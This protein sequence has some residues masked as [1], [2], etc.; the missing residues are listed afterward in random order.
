MST[1]WIP[2]IEAAFLEWA[3]VHA[4]DLKLQDMELHWRHHKKGFIAISRAK[5]MVLKIFLDPKDIE[6]LDHEGTNLEMFQ[7]GPFREH[8]PEYLGSGSTSQGAGWLLTTFCPDPSFEKQKG[9][10]SFLL[11]HMDKYFYP[12]M[13]KLYTAHGF[14]TFP[15]EVWL[16]EAKSRAEKHPSQAVIKK[17]IAKIESELNTFPDYHVVETHIHH[18]LHKGN[19]L[20]AEGRLTIIDWEGMIRGLVLVDT[21][22]FPKRYLKKNKFQFFLFSLYL[23]G[24]LKH[25]PRA[26]R[27]FFSQFQEWAQA[28]F[29]ATVPDGSLKVSFMIYVL[30]RCLNTWEGRKVDRLKNKKDFEYKMLKSLGI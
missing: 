23:K 21:F 4:A 7:G 17:L 25:P 27:D 8:V 19:I 1:E 6:R 30:E 14:K 22:D 5:N 15:A 12:A 11:K 10:E 20:S 24:L 9:I 28:E 2:K 3:K 16:K 13:T 29:A 18:D 26:V